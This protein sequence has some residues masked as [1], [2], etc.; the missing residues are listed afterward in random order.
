MSK[1]VLIFI[2]FYKKK[3]TIGRENFNNREK[4][5][6]STSADKYFFILTTNGVRSY[7]KF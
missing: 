7:P 6:D 2:E 3:L 1:K 4:Q 5:I